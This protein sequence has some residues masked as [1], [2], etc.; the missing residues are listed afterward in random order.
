[1]TRNYL[2]AAAIG[3]ERSEDGHPRPSAAT[4]G[5]LIAPALKCVEV[6]L[7]LLDVCVDPGALLHIAAKQGK[8]AAGGARIALRGSKLLTLFAQ[9]CIVSAKLCRAA[10]A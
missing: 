3:I 4:S 8:T 5:R 9:G 6:A 2:I 1:M 10:T 7:H